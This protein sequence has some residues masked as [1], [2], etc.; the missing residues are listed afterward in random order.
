MR[1]RSINML[2]RSLFLISLF[3]SVLLLCF[4]AEAADMKGTW[5]FSS[6]VVVDRQYLTK[7][8]TI[9]IEDQ[10]NK[11]FYGTSEIN[12][13]GQ[14]YNCDLGGITKN[15]AVD[16]NDCDTMWKGNVMTS[17]TPVCIGDVCS[18][19]VMR[20]EGKAIFYIQS[21]FMIAVKVK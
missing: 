2:R 16:I 18:N 1:S 3:A 11:R 9:T 20:L 7:T 17:I 19:T 13:E 4:S 8:G 15:D 12:F 14:V 21:E 6:Q 10:N 5:K